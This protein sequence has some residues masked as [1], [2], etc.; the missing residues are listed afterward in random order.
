MRQSGLLPNRKTTGRN[1]KGRQ[2]PTASLG[3]SSL[4]RAFERV[5]IAECD[6][7]GGT[8]STMGKSPSGW[9]SKRRGA[10]R[11]IVGNV[12]AEPVRWRGP[13]LEYSRREEETGP[14]MVHTGAASTMVRLTRADRSHWGRRCGWRRA[15]GRGRREDPHGLAPWQGNW[16]SWSACRASRGRQAGQ[17]RWRRWRSRCS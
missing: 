16:A 10:H 2:S 17:T 11:G 3:E 8:T 4:A 9:M 7:A 14:A 6:L 5:T 13:R 15:A 12:A 1:R